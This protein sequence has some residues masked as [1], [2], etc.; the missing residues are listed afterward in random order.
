MKILVG[1]NHLQRTGGTESYTYAL[2]TELKNLGHEVEYFTF[3]KGEV[4]DIFEQEGIPFMSQSSYDL[5]LANHT[6]V[7]EKLHRYGYIIQT[8]HGTKPILEQP[9]PFADAHISVTGEIQEYLKTKGIQSTILHNGIDC[10]RFFPQ[11]PI[12]QHLSCVLSL[13]QSDKLNHFIKDC[14]DTMGIKFISCNKFSDNVWEI[15]RKINE[16][17]LVVGIGRSL[18]DA[19]ACGRCVISYDNRRYIKESIGDGYIDSNNI[20]R[21]IF[22]NCSGRGIRKTFTKE[23][24]IEELKKYNPGDGAWARQYALEHL[25]MAHSAAI[26]LSYYDKYQQ[27]IVQTLQHR[28]QKLSIIADRYREQEIAD[29]QRKKKLRKKIKR[30]TIITS[31]VVALAGIGMALLLK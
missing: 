1:N 4:S 28:Y 30:I 6:T 14:C 8:C 21:A 27:D 15:E 10:K 2:A 26:Y 31:I 11:K 29:L 23:Q 22:H 17:D 24:F 18:Y 12:S 9:S 16:A 5:I 25:N 13:S 3:V 7:V 19:M 20:E